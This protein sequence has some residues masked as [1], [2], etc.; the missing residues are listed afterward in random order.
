MEIE[1][2]NVIAFKKILFSLSIFFTIS[3]VVLF[4]LNMFYSER[5]RVG[6]KKQV[7]EEKIGFFEEPPL[8]LG[9]T[10]SKTSSKSESK[11][12]KIEDKQPKLESKSESKETKSI[13]DLKDL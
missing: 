8:D 1:L 4:V 5:V 13:F 6:V 10:S 3:S 11:G 12:S 2:A 7:K 9:K